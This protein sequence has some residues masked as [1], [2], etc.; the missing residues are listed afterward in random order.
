MKIVQFVGCVVLS[1][2]IGQAWGQPVFIE[3]GEDCSK[4]VVDSTERTCQGKERAD[5]ACR[6]RGDLVHWVVKPGDH[7]FEVM[8]Q[9]DSPF[10][11]DTACLTQNGRP[12]LIPDGTPDGNYIYNVRVDIPGCGWIDP[13][14]LVR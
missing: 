10:G 4:T 13:R 6:G 9:G 5:D 8:F 14:I 3:V 7:D 12:C 1:L 2:A 11:D